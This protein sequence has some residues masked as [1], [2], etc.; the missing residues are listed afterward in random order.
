[1]SEDPKFRTAVFLMVCGGIQGIFISAVVFYI[2]FVKMGIP[3][4]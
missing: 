4:P 3:L 2:M 1:M